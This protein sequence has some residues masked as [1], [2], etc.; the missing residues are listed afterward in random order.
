M[1]SFA[2]CLR[3][4]DMRKEK[5]TY[6]AMML[7]EKKQHLILKMRVAAVSGRMDLLKELSSEYRALLDQE[8]N[9]K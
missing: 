8:H 5:M 4:K 6:Q 7:L 9:N 3:I 2:L 1:V